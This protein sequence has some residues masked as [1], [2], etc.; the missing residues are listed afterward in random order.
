MTEPRCI[1]L[2]TLAFVLPSIAW[3]QE[4]DAKKLPQDI[5]DKGSA[6]Y[7]TKDAAAMVATYTADA[8]IQ[9]Y[10]RRIPESSSRGR[11]PDAQRSKG[12]IVTCSKTP[13]QDDL[14][15]YGGIRPTPFPDVLVMITG[16]FSRMWPT[17]ESTRSSR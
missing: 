16:S 3:S 11:R 1:G 15:K 10:S 2:I 5:L 14:Q 9:W 17:R 4:S 8:T 13:R 7:D 12:S 6:L